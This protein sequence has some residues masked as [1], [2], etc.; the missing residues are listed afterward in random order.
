MYTQC[1]ACLTVFALD[2]GQLAQTHGQVVC[3][4]CA[5]PFDALA[6]LTAQL[7]PEPFRQLPPAGAGPAPVLEG[8]VYR[9]AEVVPAAESAAP[10]F[11]ARRRAG[12]HDGVW[13]LLCLVLVLLLAGQLGWAYRQALIA[14][15]TL[16]GG[17]RTLCA[18]LGCRLPAVAAPDRLE[19]LQRD[20]RVH[21]Q[22][23]G[24]LL[25]SA[26]VHNAA[27]FTQPYPV[28]RLVLTDARGRPVAMRRLRPDEYLDDPAMLYEGLPAGANVTLVVELADPGRRA[29]G[30][31]LDFE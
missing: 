18:R 5:V 7:P 22:V 28:V 24:A 14:D 31:T 3:G 10:A 1:P 26:T 15:P 6:R 20:L 17:L 29:T 12:R 2:V 8:A 19:L 4:H 30:F 9:P 13:A 27:P 23:P 11:V 16:G 25:V 21:P